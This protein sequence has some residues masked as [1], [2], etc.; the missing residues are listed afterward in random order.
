MDN[1]SQKDELRVEHYDAAA[2]EV[3]RKKMLKRVGVGVGAAIA[4]AA[5]GYFGWTQFENN[6]L[7]PPPPPPGGGGA[8]FEPVLED[9]ED[10]EDIEE[11]DE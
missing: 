10:F 8:W 6:P 4:A 7:T 3:K 1:N 9:I 5:L 11:T 2:A